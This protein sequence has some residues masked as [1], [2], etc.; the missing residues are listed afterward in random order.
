MVGSRG[1]HNIY[2]LEEAKHENIR[3]NHSK[4]LESMMRYYNTHNIRLK[5]KQIF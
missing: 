4:K 1:T 2:I 5:V 3:Y